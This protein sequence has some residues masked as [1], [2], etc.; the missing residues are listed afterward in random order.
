MDAYNALDL[1]MMIFIGLVIILL[2]TLAILELFKMQTHKAASWLARK[3][4]FFIRTY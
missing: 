1:V 2:C 4:H 3:L